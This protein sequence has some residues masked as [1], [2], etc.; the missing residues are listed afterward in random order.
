MQHKQLKSIADFGEKLIF[1]LIGLSLLGL[2]LPQKVEFH[3]NLWK[4][5]FIT[6]IAGIA[7]GLVLWIRG[8]EE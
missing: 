3:L 7:F 2:V 4:A 5:A 8:Q 6:G 1:V